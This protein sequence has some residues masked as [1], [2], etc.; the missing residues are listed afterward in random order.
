MINLKE[1]INNKKIDIFNNIKEMIKLESQIISLKEDNQKLWDKI[2][3]LEE[4]IINSNRRN[5][6]LK[7]LHHKFLYL[8]KI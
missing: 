4:I 6:Y 7:R 5:I 2:Y 3:K 1:I 8:I